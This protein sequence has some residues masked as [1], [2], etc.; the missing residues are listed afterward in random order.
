MARSPKIRFSGPV[1]VFQERVL[2]ERATPAGYA[3]LIDAYRL[4]A[5]VPRTLSATGEHHRIRQDNS[6]WRSS[7]T[8][9]PAAR[10]PRRPH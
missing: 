8:P 3:A 7:H 1:T 10:Y 6:G 5:P 9:P 2:P 4:K